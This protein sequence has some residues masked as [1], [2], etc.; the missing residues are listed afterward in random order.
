MVAT[1]VGNAAIGIAR[2]CKQSEILIFD[3]ATS[4]PDGITEDIVMSS[5]QKLKDL[6]NYYLN[7]TWL[8]DT[9][10]RCHSCH[11]TRPN[12]WSGTYEELLERRYIQKMAKAERGIG[13]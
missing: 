8:D 11:E 5:I 6:K 3:E 13:K 1:M 9:G 4:A 7:R 10:L 12:Y 2:R